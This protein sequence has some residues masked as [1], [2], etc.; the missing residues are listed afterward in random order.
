MGTSTLEVLVM[1]R[2]LV[3]YITADDVI[4]DARRDHDAAFLAW[5]KRPDALPLPPEP[6]DAPRIAIAARLGSW[7]RRLRL[8]PA[9]RT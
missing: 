3:R 6:A 9:T 5:H 7:M 2:F 8:R 4:A 1:E